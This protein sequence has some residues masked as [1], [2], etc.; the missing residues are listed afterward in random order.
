M[1]SGRTKAPPAESL[2][3]R[4][5]E[6]IK[7]DILGAAFV[8]GEKLAL[9]ALASR[10]AIGLNP[11]REALH[12]LSSEG[13]V[14]RRSQRGF[15]VASMSIADL[16]ELVRARI[17]LETK[18]L[19]ESMRRA[20]DEWEERLIVAYHR[21][22]R[23]QRLIEV[24]DCERLNQTWEALHKEFHMQLLARCG[25]SW[26][27]GFCSTMMD[28]SVR[29]RNLSVNFTKARRGDAVTEHRDILDAVL[30]RD[31]ARATGLLETHYATTLEGLR[32]IIG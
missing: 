8:P 23:T 5:H 29:Y 28:Q 10:Y 11:V 20:S 24:E 6:A 12:R 3:E 18:A 22:A 31:E 13:F 2:S 4:A 19:S 26:L 32:Q 30:D 17:W 14:E 9:D 1:A 27:L 15:F 7:R 21:L 16:D 25:S